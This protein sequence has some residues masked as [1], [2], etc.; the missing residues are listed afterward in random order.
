MNE[1]KWVPGPWTLKR[2]NWRGEPAG[3]DIY[4]SGNGHES[5]DDDGM[6][7][8]VATSV[9]IVPGNANGAKISAATA[10]LI[11]ASPDLYAVCEET[12]EWL[13]LWV[14]DDAMDID[15]LALEGVAVLATLSAALAKARKE[16]TS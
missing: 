15:D 11:C 3:H 6:P 8:L 12:A 4:I 1:P 10:A 9:A 13:K 16:V 2:T 7:S 14:D 5:Y